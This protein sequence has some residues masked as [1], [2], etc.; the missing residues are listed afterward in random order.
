MFYVYQS[1]EHHSPSLL[2]YYLSP[3]TIGTPYYISP[4]ICEGKAYNEKSDI[5]SLG[6]VL[7]EIACLQKTFEG[8]TLPALVN[9]IMK[10]QYAPLRGDYSQVRSEK[11][12]NEKLTAKSIFVI[13]GEIFLFKYAFFCSITK[14][15]SNHLSF[16]TNLAF[17]AQTV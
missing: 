4:E 9:K 10:G 11:N 13:P 16:E 2:S 6:C 8:T 17:V 3:S 7:Y 15:A 5:W 12:E 1:Q 14:T